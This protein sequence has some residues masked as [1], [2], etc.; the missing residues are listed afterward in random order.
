[1]NNHLKMKR[2]RWNLSAPAL[3]NAWE[4]I[5]ELINELI[6]WWSGVAEAQSGQVVAL[7]R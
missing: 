5:N 7:F 1:M 3:M 2:E 6:W 4:L